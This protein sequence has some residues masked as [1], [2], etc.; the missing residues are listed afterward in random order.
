MFR[1]I[2]KTTTKDAT[3]NKE[4]T[5]EPMAYIGRKV[6]AK[7]KNQVVGWNPLT[8]VNVD[9]LLDLAAYANQVLIEFQDQMHTE[10]TIDSFAYST[11]KVLPS[12][13]TSPI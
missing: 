13:L 6:M 3:D 12:H 10:F 7:F 11:A 9:E 4:Y 1:T 8:D 5:K 2:V